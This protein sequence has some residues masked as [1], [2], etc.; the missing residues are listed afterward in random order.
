MAE[1]GYDAEMDLLISHDGDDGYDDYEQEVDRNHP[2]QAGGASTQYH[3]SE[4][5]EM[6][7]GLHEHSGLL[8]HQA[9]TSFIEGS[10][11]F[12]GLGREPG[13]LLSEL[14]DRVFGVTTTE[15]PTTVT[16]VREF[17]RKQYP[18]ADL[19]L[20][21]RIVERGV[22]NSVGKAEDI[23]VVGP[24][25]EKSGTKI[26]VKDGY[27]FKLSASFLAENE[28]LLGPKAQDLIKQ[29][30]QQECQLQR[31]LTVER[32]QLKEA[33]K[34]EA[35]VA[36]RNQNRQK[37]ENDLARTKARREQLEEDGGSILQNVAEIER[38]KIKE[39][40]LKRDIA[41]EKKK[42]RRPP[43]TKQG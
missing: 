32:Q 28:K 26:I 31:D 4:E 42:N 10:R 24:K 29:S 27:G 21:G 20:L 6:Q 8:S 38:L 19:K 13:G 15:E 35:E 23:I 3:G 39:N 1:G 2:F 33:E 25:G 7:T 18:N 14:S 30:K 5:I 16:E 37:Y 40:G 36:K 41:D 17:V 12:A 22:K 11:S 34:L 43:K 9:E